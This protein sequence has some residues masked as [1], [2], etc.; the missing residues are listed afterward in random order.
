MGKLLDLTGQK[1]NRLTV[2]ERAPDFFD[3]NGKR[4]TK[5]LCKCDCGKHVSVATH[6]LRSGHTSSCGCYQRERTS[7]AG[8]K[9]GLKH[10]AIYK[11][12]LAIKDRCFNSRNKRFHC[13][14]GRG[15]TVCEEWK[16]DFQAFYNY[17]S[18][19][20]HFGEKGY[21]LDRIDNNGNYEPNNVRW[22][23]ETEQARNKS[24]TL[25]IEH[26]EER[27]TISEWSQITGIKYA[28]LLHRYHLGLADKEIFYKG[29]LKYGTKNQRNCSS[30]NN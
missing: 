23:T 8:K 12:W 20:P 5:W 28:T 4:K 6:D 30:K 17:V 11:K 1:Y 16:N 2:I 21:S 7:E 15:I 10:T 13:Y 14:G 22:A 24:N 27:K 25:Y 26:N 29:V 3:K 18:M 9:H 19:L